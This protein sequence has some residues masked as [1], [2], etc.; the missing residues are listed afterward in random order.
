MR[1]ETAAR[2]TPIVHQI[3]IPN[4]F[5]EGR[6][7]VYVIAH[8]PVTLIDTGVASGTAF[9]VL[10][11]GLKEHGLQVRDI[12]RVVLTHKHIDHLGNAWRV[13]QIAGA[14]V[15][16]HESEYDAVTH[17]DPD[18]RE[19]VNLVLGRL[20]EWQAPLRIHS[21]SFTDVM[22]RWEIEPADARG[23]ID[24]ER[25]PFDGGE[26]EVIHTP[27]HTL[28]S[29]CLAYRNQLFTGDHVLPTLSPNVGGG[30]LGHRG[31]LGQFYRSLDRI[32]RYAPGRVALPGHGVPFT[33]VAA[34]CDELIQHHDERL[35]KI[36][37]ILRAGPLTVYQIAERL[38][39]DMD[40]FHVVLGCA[41]A[42]AHLEW[43]VDQDQARWLEAQHH[44]APK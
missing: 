43:L 30:D 14:E 8:D 38:F 32:K 44:Y 25:L 42:Q 40:D 33:T 12:R 13:Q 19:F 39:G 10:Q 28:G 11:A 5:F 41:E 24:G 1:R 35:A 37:A 27:G 4:P 31:L 18:G 15:C 34:R 6:N 2:M 36:R 9:G 29:I 22:P 16:I 20:C 17:V 21:E 26:M 23:L 7:R 3:A